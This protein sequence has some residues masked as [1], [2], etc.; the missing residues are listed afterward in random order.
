MWRLEIATNYSRSSPIDHKRG[1]VWMC[2]FKS[3]KEFCVWTFTSFQILAIAATSEVPG[4][5]SLVTRV[6]EFV[7][8]F[9]FDT[10]YIS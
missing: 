1:K 10:R 4:V 7:S 2:A 9:N 8:F 5:P 3:S 6:Y